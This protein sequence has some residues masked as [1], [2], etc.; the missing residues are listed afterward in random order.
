MTSKTTNRLL[1]IIAIN[2]TV[3]T[4][5]M[6]LQSIPTATAHP[7][8]YGFRSAVWNTAEEVFELKVK[9]CSVSTEAKRKRNTP[10]KI[11]YVS[12]LSC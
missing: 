5:L 4:G 10:K 8:A 3:L 7:D 1:S 12:Y 2:L 6:V 9:S 11:Y